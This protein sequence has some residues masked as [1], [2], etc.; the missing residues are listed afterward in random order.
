MIAPAKMT[1][2]EQK[3]VD[4]QRDNKGRFTTGRWKPGQSGNP[5]GRPPNKKYI[6][7]A[8][9]ELLESDPELLKELIKAITGKAKK[10]DVPA[11]KEISDRVEGKVADK[12][13]GTDT[14]V[15]IILKRAEDRD[16]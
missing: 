6:S 9:R 4:M 12:I 10:G 16:A 1:R 8:L 13:E 3:S 2:D 15:T 5:K 11:F 7:E 14:P